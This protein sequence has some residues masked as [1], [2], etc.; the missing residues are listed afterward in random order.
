MEENVT[1]FDKDKDS[2]Y[3]R[4]VTQDITR[5]TE[6]NTQTKSPVCKSEDLYQ[7][8]EETESEKSFKYF[9]FDGNEAIVFFKKVLN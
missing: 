9:D 6:S 7:M 5:E 8:C 3:Y 2:G 1:G 4:L